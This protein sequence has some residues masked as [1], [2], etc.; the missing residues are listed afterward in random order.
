MLQKMINF[1]NVVK[2]ETKEHWNWSEI[3]DHPYMLLIFGGSGSRKTNSLFNL[4]NEQSDIDNINLCA[5]DLNEAKY[6]FL[7]KKRED[8]ETKHFNDSKGFIECSDNMVDIYKNI[9]NY[10]PIKN[11]KCWSNLMIWLL[12][13]LIV[14]KTLSNSNR[15]VYLW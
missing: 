10:N 7:I 6:Q 14:K 8:V 13:C 5:K 3:R 1:D 4:T 12:I 15:I 2:E 9:K 11:E